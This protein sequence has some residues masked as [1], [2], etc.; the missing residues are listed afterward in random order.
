MLEKDTEDK[1]D[2]SCEKLRNIMQG[3]EGHTTCPPIFPATLLAIGAKC[4]N[5]IQVNFYT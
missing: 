1:L 5:I 4:S 2:R 3:Q